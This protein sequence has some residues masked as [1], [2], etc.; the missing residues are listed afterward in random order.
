MKNP[1]REKRALQRRGARALTAVRA[2]LGIDNFNFDGKAVLITGGSRGLGLVLARRLGRM[3][4]R[5]A[6]LARDQEELRRARADLRE[7]G[8]DVLAIQCDVRDSAQVEVAVRAVAAQLGPIDVLINNA[9][10]IT[11]GP[12][13]L[14]TDEDHE[15]AL[16][17]HFWGPLHMTLAVLP[18]MRRRGRGRIVNISSI[19]GKVPVPHLLPYCASKFALTALS[20]GMRAELL[21]DGV[22]VTTVCPGLMRTGSV[23]H[24][25]FKGQHRAE[26]AWFAI[27]DSLPLLS[28]GAE[29][30]AGKILR[31]VRRGR[32]EITLGLPAKIA[33]KIHGI[34]PGLWADRMGMVNRV[35]PAPGGI[36]NQRAKGRDSQ[37][38]LSSSV[39]TILT[40]RAA[41]RNNQL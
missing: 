23:F 39:L 16:Q 18:E 12:M 41:K 19:G 6:I 21:K 36:G 31:A 5:I 2:M 38:R 15:E 37:S 4:A 40:Q 30:A 3:G 33:A 17:T 26:F 32:A 7:R 22:V 35:L 34:F 8:T 27:L 13:E 14:M 24:A 25:Q 10:V 9:G 11:V 1:N 20:E 29:R 28:M